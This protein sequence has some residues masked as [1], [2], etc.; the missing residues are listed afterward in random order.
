MNA[1]SPDVRRT[2][3]ALPDTWYK[4]SPRKLIYGLIAVWVAAVILPA[5]IWH[6]G[7]TATAHDHAR[8]QTQSDESVGDVLLKW[9][10]NLSWYI[11]KISHIGLPCTVIML[12]LYSIGLI[13]KEA[14]ERSE[15]RAH[16]E[17]E[18]AIQKQERESLLKG[19]QDEV[20]KVGEGLSRTEGLF[21]DFQSLIGRENYLQNIALG[22]SS[23]KHVVMFTS[24]TMESS[25]RSPAQKDIVDALMA[26]RKRGSYTHR[27][28]VARQPSTLTGALEIM[29][30]TA[31]DGN[32]TS[33]VDI[34]MSRILCM[35]RLRFVVIDSEVSIIGVARGDP[36]LDYGTKPEASR[37]STQSVRIAS[38]ML[39]NSL[40][41][42]FEELWESSISAI[43]YLDEYITDAA[44]QRNDYS[45]SEVDRWL[46]VYDVGIDRAWLIE[47]SSAYRNLPEDGTTGI[48]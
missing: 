14:T 6:E 44:M 33:P 7:R 10:S 30:K 38:S 36:E 15:Y 39:G 13:R 12:E 22:I 23:A 20:N 40:S 28:V 21:R 11:F 35:T 41:V 24:A 17:I 5:L 46:R 4:T 48:Q 31:T 43:E 19:I 37:P 9:F 16:R 3:K 34:R 8:A 25:D 2:T 1:T 27:G 42:K 47:N 29:S 45:R 26:R 18:R 32:T